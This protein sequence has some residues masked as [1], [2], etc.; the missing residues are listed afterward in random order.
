MV[1]LSL[2]SLLAAKMGIEAS[3]INPLLFLKPNAFDAFRKAAHEP[4]PSLHRQSRTEQKKHKKI[5]HK[6]A[7]C[8]N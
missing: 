3:G 2:L 5:V 8:T 6:D 1:I 7:N 4:A